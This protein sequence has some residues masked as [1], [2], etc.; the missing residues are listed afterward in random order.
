LVAGPQFHR[1]ERGG[2]IF[3]GAIA[4]TEPDGW[5]RRVILRDHAKRRQDARRAGSDVEDRP[6][7]T[8]DVLLAVDDASR[9]GALRFQ[10]EE[11]IFQRAAEEGRRTAPPLIELGQLLAASRAVETNSETA[12][13]LQYL[14]ISFRAGT[15]RIFATL[16]GFA[17]LLFFFL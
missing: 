14:S 6:L 2:S 4:D 16:N 11:G 5:A 13:D 12:A 17:P 9:V 15:N 8:L 1:R 10:D 7:N 3:H